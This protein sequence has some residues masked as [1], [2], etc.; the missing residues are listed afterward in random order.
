MKQSIFAAMTKVM[1]GLLATGEDF[2]FDS[3]KHELTVYQ[4]FRKII[5]RFEPT[6]DGAIEA[7]VSEAKR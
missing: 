4:A 7:T 3:T 5:I 2:T 1:E 6:S